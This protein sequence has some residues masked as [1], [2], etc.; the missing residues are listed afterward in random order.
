MH[1]TLLLLARG[2]AL[3]ALAMSLG[4]CGGPRQLDVTGKVTYNGVPLAKPNGKIAFISPEGVQVGASINEDGTYTA[5]KVTAGPNRVAVY[6]PNPA[7]HVASRPKGL[8]TAK[9]RPALIPMYLTPEKYSNVETSE[10]SVTVDKGTVFNVD[11]T[12][13]PISP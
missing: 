2:L 1:R 4:G 3:G 5:T 8:P 9:D 10:L 6:Y 13:P 12:G 7:F 11:M